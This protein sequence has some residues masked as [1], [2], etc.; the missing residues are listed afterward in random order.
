MS[1]KLSDS[2]KSKCDTSNLNI[3]FYIYAE[4][5]EIEESE[6]RTTRKGMIPAKTTMPTTTFRRSKLL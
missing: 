5:E 4:T 3:S 2:Q 1:L 6:E